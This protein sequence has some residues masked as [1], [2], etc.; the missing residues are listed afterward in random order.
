MRAGK[1][2]QSCRILRKYQLQLNRLNLIM[3]QLSHKCPEQGRECR[4]G[5]G[6]RRV[7]GRKETSGT[8]GKQTLGWG[9]GKRVES[10]RKIGGG[11]CQAGTSTNQYKHT[12]IHS[13]T[14]KTLHKI[15]ERTK[16]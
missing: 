10:G 1:E 4:Q 14:V 15:N 8:T 12:Y 5:R 11:T 16:V 13:A 3:Q 9:C 6:K 2:R 7:W